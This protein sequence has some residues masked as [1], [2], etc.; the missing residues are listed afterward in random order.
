M[1]AFEAR[2]VH[3]DLEHRL[4]LGQSRNFRR[5]EFERQKLLGVIGPEIRAERRH[6]KREVLAQHAVLGQVA[7]VLQRLFDGAHLL[8]RLRSHPHAAIRIETQLEELEQHR[9]DTRV[10]R[11]RRLDERLRQREPDLTQILGVCAQHDNVGCRY[12]GGDDEPI[13]IVVFDF[14]AKDAAERILEHA[15]QCVDLDF[16]VDV[17]RQHA[18][19]VHPDRLAAFRNDAMR[20]LV[21]DFEPHVLEH[22]QAQRQRDRAAE[23]E[24]LE[25]HHAGRRLERPIERHRERRRCRKPV[26]HFDVGDGRTSRE[27]F[28]ITG[29]K[30]RAE[31][32]EQRVAATFAE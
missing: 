30:R 16:G 4:R 3:E 14:A 27:V 20:S 22:R 6:D 12:A 18:E 7:D 32:L 31:C 5:I 17:R 2:G 29:G 26:H 19:I 10:S 1:D 23:M 28:A 21:D 25:A 24:Q 11:Q 9:R 15:M 13:E 8:R